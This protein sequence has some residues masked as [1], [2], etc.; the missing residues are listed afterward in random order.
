MRYEVAIDKD[1]M[2][3]NSAALLDFLKNNR[4]EPAARLSSEEIDLQI[5]EERE[6]WEYD[7][8]KRL[9][10]LADMYSSGAIT[11]TCEELEEFHADDK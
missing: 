2:A 8:I 7:R 4:L 3:G 1:G 5:C 10:H 6:A 11:M 9:E